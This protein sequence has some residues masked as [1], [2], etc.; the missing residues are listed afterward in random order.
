MPEGANADVIVMPVHNRRPITLQTLQLLAAQGV[1]DWATLLV[2]DDGSTDGTAEAI[3]RE[4]PN[5]RLFRGDGTWWWGGA[6]RRGMEWALDRGAA[7]IFWLNDD[8]R[9]PPG[10]LAAL[11]DAATAEC[12]VVWLAA[13]AESG[14]SYGGHRKTLW[15]IRRCT[16]AE[17][18]AGSHETFSGNCVCLPR[19]QVERVG[20]PNDSAFPH[21]FADLDYGLR[22]HAAG[23]PLRCLPGYIAAAGEPSL[24]A[25]ERWLTSPRS[26]RE[27]ARDFTSPRSFLYPPAW[28]RF[29]RAH[30]GL[31]W[32]AIVFALPYVRWLVIAL[33]RTLA[34][35]LAR[36]LARRPVR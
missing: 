3:G 16:L 33:L 10:A 6:T 15:T 17:E 26:M 23:A 25:S 28:R 12:A 19:P 9:P 20:L 36:A 18:R 8:C 32:G 7:R 11:R 27:I 35:P 14:W 2:V 29:T 24:A 34:P 31:I 5:V 4:F 21:G 13:H 30:W 1:L 22:L